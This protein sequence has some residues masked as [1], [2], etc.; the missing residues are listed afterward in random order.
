MACWGRGRES[1][2]MGYF[3]FLI[4]ALFLMLDSVCGFGFLFLCLYERKKIYG[5]CALLFSVFLTDTLL[6]SMAVF[7]PGFDAFYISQVES[8]PVI[9]SALIV[10]YLESLFWIRTGAHLLQILLPNTIQF[11]IF[12]GAIDFLL[13][14]GGLWYIL[15]KLFRLIRQPVSAPLFSEE[16]LR[17]FAALYKLTA[18]EAEIPALL[19]LQMKNAEIAERLHISLGTVKVHIHNIFVKAEVQTRRELMGKLPRL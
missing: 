4:N 1:G 17:D 15:R 9:R 2:T 18:R 14:V 10:A 19:A 12:T 13:G 3:D 8:E 11:S 6:F 7:L 16:S 5:W